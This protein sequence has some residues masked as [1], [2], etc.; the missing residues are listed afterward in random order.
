MKYRHELKFLV[1]D[2]QLEIIR[3]RLKPLMRPDAHQK[4]EAYAVRSLY[5]DDFYDSCMRENEDGIDN[6]QKFRIR[7]YDGDAAM[8]RLEKKIKCHGMTGKVSSVISKEDCR[9]YMAGRTP[10]FR[11]ESTALEKELYVGIK[12]RG[13]HP[14]SI[15]EYE[16]TAF[17]D[18]KGNVRITF[19]RNIRGNEKTEGFLEERLYAVP[20]LPQRN[21]VLEVKYD[22]LLPEY[23]FRALE[24]GTLVRTAF[25][26][27]CY[28]RRYQNER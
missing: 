7:I 23:I 15:V 3:Y 1:S 6:R 17:V 18:P 4:G 8:I 5:F 25:S 12:T 27:Y 24:T 14:A 20:L 11:Q 19:D 9:I 26:K 21:H 13:L 28:S 10:G 2:A 16:R 22:E